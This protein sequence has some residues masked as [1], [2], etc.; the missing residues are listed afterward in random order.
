M[1]LALSLLLLV[2]QHECALWTDGGCLATPCQFVYGSDAGY[3]E[4][5]R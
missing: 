5:E 1:L 2:T 3:C 4:V